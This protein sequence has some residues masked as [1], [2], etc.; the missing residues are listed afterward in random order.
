MIRRL[1]PLLAA[2]LLLLTVGC[3]SVGDAAKDIASEAAT[4]AGT[5]AAAELQKQVCAPVQDGQLSEQ[6]QQVLAGLLQAADA[7]GLASEF[8]TPLEDLVGGPVPDDAVA[9]LLDACGVT[10]TPAPSNG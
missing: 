10:A 4:Q 2:P 9:A 3:S 7:S 1:A 5:A 8:T 6:D